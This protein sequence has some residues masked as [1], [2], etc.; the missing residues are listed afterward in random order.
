MHVAVSIVTFNSGREVAACLAALGRSQHP[1]FEVIICE[2][3]GP[4]AFDAL[5]ATLPARLEGGQSIRAVLAPG[6][7]GYAGGVN[8]CIAASSG[9]TFSADSRRSRPAA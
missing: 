8:L 5:N 9:V 3:G 4:Q 7:L 6:N 1:D 2:N